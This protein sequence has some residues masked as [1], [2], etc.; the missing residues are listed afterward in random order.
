[1]QIEQI[2]RRELLGAMAATAVAL[3]FK[4]ALAAAKYKRCNVT[5]VEGRKALV[6]YAKGVEAMLSLPADHPH[7]WFRNAFVHLLDCPHGNWWFYVWHR[8]YLGYFEQT[9]RSL[10]GDPDFA[11][12]YWDWTELPQIPDEMFA[13]VLSPT[14]DVFKPYTENFAV[15]T[16]FIE[17]TLSRYW[18]SLSSAQKGQLTARTYMQFDDLWKG[19]LGVTGKGVAGNECFAPTCGA[20]YLSKTNPHLDGDTTRAVSK[21][22]VSAGLLA[23][24]FYNPVNYLSFNSI[25]SPSHNTA[26][27]GAPTSFS[28]LEGMPHNLVH[29][30][31]GGQGPL[32]PGPYG[33][34]TN[35]LSPVDPVFFLH[36]SNMDRLWDVWTRKQKSR[37]QPYL[38]EGDDLKTLSDEPFLFFVDANGD[39]V[40]N[41]KAGD[42]LATDRFDYDYDDKGFGET[43]VGPEVADLA[44]QK[45]PV[46]AARVSANAASVEVPAAILQGRSNANN[47]R[48]LVAQVTLMRP[49]GTSSARRFRVFVGA[50]SDATNLGVDSPYYAGTVGFFGPQMADMGM[51]HEATFAV[52]L[53]ATLHALTAPF[54]T[55]ATN[56]NLAVRVTPVNGE[57]TT[58]VLKAVSIGAL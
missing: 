2:T 43:L 42:Y 25:K 47:P 13:G 31:I 23:P 18:D 39:Y 57:E 11:L 54:A 45:P 44:T 17:P 35:F 7:N 8:G 40:L 12:P 10:S 48:P 24:D 34:M 49:Q 27:T 55:T 30:C 41:G 9:I 21:L 53:P 37:H 50:P 26:S 5:S 6:S 4:P 3:P 22:T 52:P 32:D 58:P 38:P 19:P 29:N 15:F 1:M 33:N 36:H 20:R 16:S 28:V 56:A 14:S 51:S 46:A